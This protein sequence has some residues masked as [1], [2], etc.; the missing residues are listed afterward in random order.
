MSDVL[1]KPELAEFLKMTVRQIDSLCETRVRARQKHPLPVFK[2]NGSVRF[3]RSKVEA[4]LQSLQE[5]AA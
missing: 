2:I 3:S 1:T 4:W 5:E